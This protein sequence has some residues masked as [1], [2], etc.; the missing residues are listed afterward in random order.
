MK[1]IQLSDGMPSNVRR[2]ELR[3]KTIELLEA[4][5]TECKKSGLSYVEMN[6]A[7]HMADEELY[8]SVINRSY[9]E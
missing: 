3:A 4:I 1:R 8:I 6:K 2:I 5:K 7:L 9:K